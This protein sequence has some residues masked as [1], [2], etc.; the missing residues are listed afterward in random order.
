MLMGESL[1]PPNLIPPIKKSPLFFYLKIKPF[2]KK[3]IFFLKKLFNPQRKESPKKGNILGGKI[4]MLN[5]ISGGM[6]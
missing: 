2:I 3:F 5:F 4:C 6:I 1:P